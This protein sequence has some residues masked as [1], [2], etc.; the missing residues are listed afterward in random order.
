MDTALRFFD[1][2][3]HHY[4]RSRIVILFEEE[5]DCERSPWTGRELESRSP[6]SQHTIIYLTQKN[7]R[8]TVGVHYDHFIATHWATASYVISLREAQEA[9]GYPLCF[10]FI[11]LIQD[12]EPGFHP[13]STRYLLANATYA[14]PQETIAVFNTD[15]L[16]EYMEKMGCVF[17]VS[18]TFEPKLNPA[19]A[20]HKSDLVNYK[21]QRLILVYG[22]PSAAR[23]AFEF[24]IEALR[25]FAEQY[26][27]VDAW[28]ALSLGEPHGNIR[29][30]SNLVLRAQGKVS[31]ERYAQHLLNASVGLSLMVSPHPSYPPLEMAEFGIR[32]ITNGFANKDLS[33]RTGNIVSV[34]DTR[35]TAFAAALIDACHA[36]DTGI[37]VN[38]LRPAFLGRED[39]FV[40]SKELA[41]RLRPGARGSERRT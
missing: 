11:Y 3:R 23:N 29:L 31:L 16:K 30:S 17:P 18:Y 2:V 6:G 32:V 4:L 5:R 37:A 9:C 34:F 25:T 39:E 12:F 38:D 14:K 19:L 26:R 24:A 40:F 10:P 41:G 20:A 35:P 7:F 21:K 1:S 15:I 27:N 8:P 13:W 22:R 28:D 33:L 36:H